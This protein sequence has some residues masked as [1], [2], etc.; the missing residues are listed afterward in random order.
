MPCGARASGEGRCGDPRRGCRRVKTALLAVLG[1]CLLV[2]A[3]SPHSSAHN[4][5]TVTRDGP[6]FTLNGQ[7]FYYAGLN[8]YYQMVFAAEP[9]LRP[10][11][12]EVQREARDLGLTVMRTWAFNDGASQWNALQ[13]APG[14]YDEHVFRGLDYV[15]ARADS[16]GLRLILPL[17]NNWDDY[18]GMNQYV[19]WSPAAEYHDDFYT[20]TDCRL[21]YRNHVATVL[22]RVNTFNGRIYREDPTVFAWELA[23]EPRCNADPSGATLRAWIA[24]MSA[25]AKSIDATHMV[26]TGSEGFYGA[27]GPNHNPVSWMRWEGVDFIAQHQVATIDFACA[28][29]YPESWGL[30]YAQSIAWVR[31]HIDDATALLGKPVILEEFGKQR[32]ATTRDAY[33]Q[34]W[35]D[36]VYQGASAGKAAGGSNFWILYHDAYPDYDGYGIYDPADGSTLAIIAAEAARMQAL[37]PPSNVAPPERGF[38]LRLRIAPNPAST[39]VTIRF[40]LPAAGPVRLEILDVAGRLVATPEAGSATPGSHAR[41][42]DGRGQNGLAAPPGLYLCRLR[43]AGA[44]ATVRLLRIG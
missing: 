43:A 33:F 15:L 19:E 5:G 23:N 16:L 22:N 36:A 26:T 44:V 7:P 42:W 29:V 38:D 40:D 27:A 24:E 1:G 28:H 4:I 14:V 9:D 11:V 8:N 10:Y 30:N 34:G 12:D 37:V 35:Y 25:Y 17:V 39:A 2:L 20:D 6:H 21:W 13:T 41:I 32:P 3:S 31:D 18:G